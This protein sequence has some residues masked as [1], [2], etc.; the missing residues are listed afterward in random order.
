MEPGSKVL[1][2]KMTKYTPENDYASREFKPFKGFDEDMCIRCE[3]YYEKLYA[4]GLTTTPF[5]PS[6]TKHVQSAL[7][8]IEPSD[9]STYQEY[10]DS[11]VLMDP[12]AWAESEFGWKPRWYQRE[13]ISCSSQYKILRAGRRIGKCLIK[14]TKVATPNGPI[15][16]ENL[17]IGDTVYDEHGKPIKI[18]NVFDQGLQEV[19]D[20]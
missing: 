3:N 4:Q 11:L 17:K 13:I 10:L 2:K 15:P 6:C 1:Y 12:I 5:P 8:Y 19:V 20:L 18:L 9:F 14:G 16:I 7:M